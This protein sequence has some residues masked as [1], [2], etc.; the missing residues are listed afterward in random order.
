[1][2]AP[3]DIYIE[4]I[5]IFNKLYRLFLQTIKTYL[6]HAHKTD[7]NPTQALIVYHIGPRT[8]K[9]S[10]V[11][12]HEFYHGS[13]PSYNIRHMIS[14]RYIST[15][16]SI[17]DRRVLFLT[18]S[19]KGKNLYDELSL[20]FQAHYEQL[21]QQGVGPLQWQKLHSYGQQLMTFWSSLLS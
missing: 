5:M 12:S 1:M 9:A 6:L 10:E 2:E 20:F 18:L 8:I 15:S 21:E 19:E 7:I 16:S 17:R 11:I 13:N 4:S 3:Q 14:S